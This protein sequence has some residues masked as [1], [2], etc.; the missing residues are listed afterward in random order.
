M[1]G[2]RAMTYSKIPNNSSE[3]VQIL[4]KVETMKTRNNIGIIS[5]MEER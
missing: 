5:E 1:V 4:H 3:Y 2:W